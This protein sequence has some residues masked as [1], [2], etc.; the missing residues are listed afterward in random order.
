[1]NV[2]SEVSHVLRQRQGEKSSHLPQ[3]KTS[4][5]SYHGKGCFFRICVPMVFHYNILLCELNFLSS[6]FLQFKSA[7]LSFKFT[8]LWLSFLQFLIMAKWTVRR[9]RSFNLSYGLSCSTH[10]WLVCNIVNLGWNFFSK[11]YIF[12]AHLQS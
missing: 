11:E 10:Y 4:K 8:M 12:V 9:L 6:F 1:M 3:C 7:A 2:L 5:L